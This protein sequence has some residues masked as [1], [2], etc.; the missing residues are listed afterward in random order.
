MTAFFNPQTQTGPQAPP[1]GFNFNM[2]HFLS[3]LSG[4]GMGSAMQNLGGVFSSQPNWSL[5]NPSVQNNAMKDISGLLPSQ[6]QNWNYRGNGVFEQDP[7]RGPSVPQMWQGMLRDLQLQDQLNKENWMR[8]QA[9]SDMFLQQSMD[10][11]KEANKAGQEQ[12]AK[13][14]QFQQQGADQAQA[15]FAR[16]QGQLKAAQ[17]K[18]G[19]DKEEIGKIFD[20]AIGTIGGGA[21]RV[22]SDAASAIQRRKESDVDQ[23]R[24][25]MGEFT[26]TESQ[27]QEA[28]RRRAADYDRELFGTI[29]NLQYKSEADKAAAMQNK[30]QIFAQ[31][32]TSTASV[33]GQFAQMEFGAGESRNKWNEFGANIAMANAKFAA[34]MASNHAQLT[35]MNYKNYADMVYRNPVLGVTITP[36]L[37]SMAE[38]AQRY[39][40]PGERI[41]PTSTRPMAFGTGNTFTYQGGAFGS[42]AEDPRTILGRINSGYR[43]R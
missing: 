40:G 27:I 10:A 20:T 32:A 19:A 28:A 3:G 7:M 35:S 26:G 6:Q 5:Q 31:L 2:D 29:A 21:D 30:G 39:G 1:A 11:A 41:A 22:A 9:A 37:L 18:M 14:Y 33:A 13:A 43:M 12:W 4:A 17:D 15:D 16:L 34:D 42:S 25:Q 24:A 8:N 38:A 23:I 36:T